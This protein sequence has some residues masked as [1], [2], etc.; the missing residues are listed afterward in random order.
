MAIEGIERKEE[1]VE[2]KI[3]QNINEDIS[4][5]AAKPRTAFGGSAFGGSAFGK[6]SLLLSAGSGSEYTL[7]IANAYKE[8]LK[9]GVN[10]TIKTEV[11]IVD[12]DTVDAELVYSAVVVAANLNGFV[13]YHTTLLAGTGRQDLTAEDIINEVNA[14]YSQKR[15]ADI[16]TAA[17]AIDEF[18]IG[19]IGA[20]CEEKWP[21][22][23]KYYPVEGVILPAY[24]DET[25]KNEI[26]SAVVIAANSVITFLAEKTGNSL[27]IDVEAAL[28]NNPSMSVSLSHDTSGKTTQ[29]VLG[30]PVLTDF[31]VSL[32]VKE[33]SNSGNRSIHAAGSEKSIASAAG[34]VE[35]IPVQVPRPA[36]AGSFASSMVRL[37]PNI[38]IGQINP[39]NNPTIGYSLLSILAAASMTSKEMYLTALAPKKG[40]VRNVGY[41]NLFCNVADEAP[42]DV[43]P[44]NL[45]DNKSTIQDNLLAID[46]MITEAPIL[47]MD[48]EEYGPNGSHTSAFVVAAMPTDSNQAAAAQSIIDAAHIAFGSA[49]PKDYPV[50]QI[51]VNAGITIPSGYWFD[52]KNNKRDLKEID[53]TFLA[54]EGADRETL[55]KWINASVPRK[56]GVDDISYL[57]RIDIISQRAPKAVITGKAIRL[58]FSNM[59]IA[60]L[61]E[62]AAKAGLNPQSMQAVQLSNIA[63]LNGIG[64]MLSGAGLTS[65][66]FGTTYVP[67]QSR[68][69]FGNNPYG[70]Y[71]GHGRFR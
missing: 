26:E 43:A 20:K 57:E 42:E 15:Q 40:D 46:T 63:N 58:T 70:N 3:Q 41:M 9:A 2:V 59:F 4:K 66:G 22:A 48:V 33:H 32:N 27:E 21:D 30:N 60:T 64:N 1:N 12:R 45:L 55:I 39:L 16:Y 19:L 50:D 11:F 5:E 44:I 51:F 8:K 29:D 14:A 47:S 25:S 56:A 18:L 13:A 6:S 23:T 69:N 49:F 35:V 17:D 67:N 10:D 65:T 28:K 61:K 53:L 37:H 52:K 38:I 24:I 34:S 31:A 71:M 7:A 36:A 62:A 68:N 54:T